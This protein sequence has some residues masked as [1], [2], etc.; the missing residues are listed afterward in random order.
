[1]PLDLQV[2]TAVSPSGVT[3][4]IAPPDPTTGQPFQR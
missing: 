2:G 4:S 3:V 1:V